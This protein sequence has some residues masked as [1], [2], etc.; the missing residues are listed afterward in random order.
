MKERLS[1]TL[2]QKLQQRLWPHQM[3]LVRLIEM[4]AAV[5]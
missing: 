5:A 3:L 4:A 2:T 1:Q